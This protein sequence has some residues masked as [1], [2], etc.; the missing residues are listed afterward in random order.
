MV[1][2]SLD[3]MPWFKSSLNTSLIIVSITKFLIMIGSQHAYC[4]IINTWSSGCPIKGI[5]LQLVL[6]DCFGHSHVYAFLPNISYSVWNLWKALLTF[7]LK[8]SSLE[9]LLILKFVID[10]INSPIPIYYNS[11]LVPRLRGIKMGLMFSKTVK[12]GKT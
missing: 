9:I 5:Q 8:R 1:P 2:G 10:A 6:V 7:T 3:A 12:V 11:T 4:H